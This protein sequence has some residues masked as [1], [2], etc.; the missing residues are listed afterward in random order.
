MC[1]QT[2]EYHELF[3]TYVPLPYR[4]ERSGCLL[5]KCALVECQ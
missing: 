2:P 1:I 4:S 5:E 3:W